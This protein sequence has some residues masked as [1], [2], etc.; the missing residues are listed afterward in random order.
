MYLVQLICHLPQMCNRMMAINAS[1]L[2]DAATEIDRRGSEK[3]ESG[4]IFGA[5]R[6]QLDVRVSVWPFAA[7]T[8]G[9]PV[10]LHWTS[11]APSKRL[12][13]AGITPILRDFRMLPAMF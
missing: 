9:P 6:C 3:L 1:P 10:K 12:N 2:Q 11:L 7:A 13:L 5:G 8:V 4:S